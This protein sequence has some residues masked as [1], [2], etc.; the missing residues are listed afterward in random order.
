MRPFNFI[1]ATF[2]LLLISSSS[3]TCQ[4]PH[5][6][7]KKVIVPLGSKA[8]LQQFEGLFHREDVRKN[9]VKLHAT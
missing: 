6:Q 5:S 9:S 2:I 4:D 3:V 8:S 7:L 1:S